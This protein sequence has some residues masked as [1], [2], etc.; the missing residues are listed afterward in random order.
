VTIVQGHFDRCGNCGSMAVLLYIT[1]GWSVYRGFIPDGDQI[2]CKLTTR[3]EGKIQEL[4]ISCSSASEDSVLF[5][6]EEMLRH[7]TG[8]PHYSSNFGCSSSSMIHTAIQQRLS[9]RHGNVSR[10]SHW[11]ANISNW[12]PYPLLLSLPRPV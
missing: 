11:I 4:V 12:K 9:F 2:I 5:Q 7:S 10:T 6:S 3:V 8:L 1:D